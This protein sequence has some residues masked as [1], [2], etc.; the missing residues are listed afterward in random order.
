MPALGLSD[1]DAKAVSM[2]LAT[3]RAP[4][5]DDAPPAATKPAG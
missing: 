3:L 1:N 5:P 4:K 2:Y